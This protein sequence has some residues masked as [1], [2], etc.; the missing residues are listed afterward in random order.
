VSRIPTN[1]ETIQKVQY[2]APKFFFESRTQIDATKSLPWEI[3][4]DEWNEE[5]ENIISQWYRVC[6]LK[7]EDIYDSK[8]DLTLV[9]P[10]DFW[11]RVDKKKNALNECPFK[12]LANLPS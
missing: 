9:D 4:P 1:F 5:K 7:C 3:L 2:F 6:L 11:V 12:E 10:L 8:K